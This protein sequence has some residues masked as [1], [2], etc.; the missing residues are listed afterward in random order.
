MVLG[1]QMGV[2]SWTAESFR[3]RASL[4]RR[5]ADGAR[6]RGAAYVAFLLVLGSFCLA[7]AAEAQCGVGDPNESH[8][9]PDG[10]GCLYDFVDPDP[11]DGIRH[12]TIDPEA[13]VVF[14]RQDCGD[15][16]NCFESM[17]MLS[18]FSDGW[19]WVGPERGGRSDPD[20]N[21]LVDI[22]P[23]TFGAFSCPGRRL[24]TEYLSILLPLCEGDAQCEADLRA[25]ST[26]E[27]AGHVTLRGAGRGVTVLT[28]MDLAHSNKTPFGALGESEGGGGGTAFRG[29]GCVDVSASQ[30]TFR[31][32]IYGVVW[33]GGGDSIW[34]DVDQ[35]AFFNPILGAPFGVGRAISTAWAGV[36]TTST[37][38]EG[39]LPIP[40]R[41][42]DRRIP[43]VGGTTEDGRPVHFYHGV[44]FK[45]FGTPSSTA[46]FPDTAF[47]DSCGENWLYGGEVTL[48][49][50][51]PELAVNTNGSVAVYLP[52]SEGS[53]NGDFRAFGT[54]ISV[55]ADVPTSGD[56]VGVAVEE[57]PNGKPVGNTREKAQFHLH[58]GI[59]EVRNRAASSERD[60]IGIRVDG[61]DASASP[62]HRALAH[63]VE[64]VFD[65]E[66]AGSGSVVRLQ[67]SNAGLVLAPFL[68]PPS[69]HPPT[70]TL[71]GFTSMHGQDLFVE[72]DCSATGECDG[73]GSQSHLMVYD[74]TCIGSGGPW[75][76]GA[77]GSCRR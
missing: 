17:R 68:W 37:N 32:S 31:G 10:T 23:G 39:W 29:Q 74:A 66:Q 67:Q 12:P 35:E 64:S 36:C 63:T 57:A 38:V 3:R 9:D 47:Y 2:S 60:V 4:G 72:T 48:H 61:Q 19:L 6:G 33:N 65:F 76:D 59:I 56:L 25:Q 27:R 50:T 7:G 43:F 55:I 22:G 41:P 21:V 53:A 14:V 77:T 75:R 69:V 44:R 46:G 62:T 13:A 51:R 70:D 16:P 58:G 73:G 15:R 24:A 54:K 34:S 20:R 18:D 52:D 8:A 49:I 71:N 40:G 26:A 30:M 1:D 45:A 11:N 42:G 28:N 5:R